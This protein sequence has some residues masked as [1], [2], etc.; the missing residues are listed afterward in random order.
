MSVST[1]VMPIV[2]NLNPEGFIPV[3]EVPDTEEMDE[4]SMAQM[5]LVFAWRTVKEVS[6][7]LGELASRAPTAD[8]DGNEIF[9][10]GLSAKVADYYRF[11]FYETKHRGA[12][13]QAAVG[14]NKLCKRIWG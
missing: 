10:L 6:L 5:L 14:F 11:I 4:S 7:L 9:D 8:S 2:N 1:V 13:E 12:Y 3:D